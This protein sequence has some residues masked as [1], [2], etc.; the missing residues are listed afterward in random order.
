[1]TPDNT[2]EALNHL[3]QAV[4]G[5]LMMDF[6]R[7]WPQAGHLDASVFYEPRHRVIFAAIQSLSRQGSGVDMHLVNDE[8]VKTGQIEQA[9][10]VL[11]LPECCDLWCYES[12]Q[13]ETYVQGL[14]QQHERRQIAGKCAELA[15]QARQGGCSTADLRN[16]LQEL[17]V[18]CQHLALPDRPADM[19]QLMKAACREIDR[20]KADDGGDGILTGFEKLDWFT[21]GLEPA[22]LVILAGRPSMGKTALAVNIALNV[23]KQ[24]TPAGFVSLEMTGREL[25]IRMISV[26]SGMP[27][28]KLR[29]RERLEDEE[30]RLRLSTAARLAELPLYVHDR[31][32]PTLDGVTSALRV[33]HAEHG[34]RLLI[35]D[36]LQL[37]APKDAPPNQNIWIAYVSQTLKGLA[38]QLEVPIL[39]LSQLSRAVESRQGTDFRPKL[40]DL[41][42]SGAIEQ[43]ADIVLFVY[44][45]E[46]YAEQLK[47][48]TIKIGDK[49]HPVAGLAEII[50]AKNRNGATGSFWMTCRLEQTSFE[51]FA[52]EQDT[53][54]GF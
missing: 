37:I 19:T 10:G 35:V 28:Q 41:R 54:P 53:G 20:R 51:N 21:N 17:L 7:F 25:G 6:T 42:D 40:S 15:A 16:E 39:C 31:C 46:V 30:I 4:L 22:N 11:Y 34:A 29:S 50:V 1:L 43:D 33:L 18:G 12:G 32:R 52:A 23:S 5:C 24:G 3:E 26:K 44:R 14:I 9:G 2:P 45:P 47:T 36:Y 8:L 49:E 27:L 48:K 13:F 38:R